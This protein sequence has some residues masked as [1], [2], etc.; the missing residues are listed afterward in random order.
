MGHSFPKGVTV[1]QCASMVHFNMP[2]PVD[3]EIAL[4]DGSRIDL[5][6]HE[7]GLSEFMKR[8]GE[9]AAFIGDDDLGML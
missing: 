9:I 6:V 4:D 1:E 3:T 2:P 7:N 5:A 8:V